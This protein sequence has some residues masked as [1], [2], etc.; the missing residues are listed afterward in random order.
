MSLLASGN[1]KE[2][3]LANYCKT[4]RQV[5]ARARAKLSTNGVV[6]AAEPGVTRQDARRK[7]QHRQK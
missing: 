3:V 6:G 4:Q 5:R 1:H 7:H 2:G